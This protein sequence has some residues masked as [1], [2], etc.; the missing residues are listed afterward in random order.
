MK[1][2]TYLAACLCLLTATAC[3]RE[4]VVQNEPEV[5]VSGTYND[6]V[7]EKGWIRI[8]LREEA[9][10]LPV[11]AF[12]R[13]AI[14]TG[15]EQLDE[16][17][18]SLGVDE[19]R[20]VFADG[21]KFAERRRKYGMHL[22]YDL[23]F[24]EQTP[25]TRAA[26]GFSELNE[27]VS[28][29]E[30]VYKI[31]P[32]D[33][34][35][36]VPEGAIY[37]PTFGITRADA[38]MP[39]NDPMLPQQW[40]YHNE[41]GRTGFIAGADI[42][43]FEAWTVEKGKPNV[44]VSVH[45][46]GANLEH[47]DL[48]AH[49]WVNE[50]EASGNEKTDDD[51][52]GYNDDVN[53]W[54]YVNNSGK[55]DYSSHG[56]HTSGTISAINGNGEGVCGVAGGNGPEDGVRIMVL[57]IYPQDGVVVSSAP[58]SYAYAADNG[59]V[60]SQNSWTLGTTGDLPK[61]YETAFD[62]FIENAGT[63]ETGK[64]TGPMK[65]GIIIFAA[66]N[67]GGQTLLPAASDRVVGVAAMIP[68]YKMGSYSNHGPEIDLFA[69]GGSSVTTAA[70]QQVLSTYS[71]NGVATYKYLWGTSMACPHVSGVAGLIV[72][73]FGGDGFTVEECRERLLNAYRPVGGLVDDANLED[74]GHGLVDAAAA[75]MNDP[76]TK[77][78]QVTEPSMSVEGTKLTFSWTVPADGN[79]AA[80]AKY[81]V[82]IPYNGA[83]TENTFVNLY[84]VGDKVTYSVYA[85][86]D[87]SLPVT[88][89][90]EDRWGNQSDPISL[91]S[92]IAAPEISQQIAD[93]TIRANSSLDLNSYFTDESGELTFSATS[94][95]EAIVAAAVKNNIL[96]LTP[97]T[98]G[99][100]KVTVKATNKGGASAEQ[101][102]SVTV[103][104]GSKPTV[105]IGPNPV[106]DELSFQISESFNGTGKVTIYDMGA[107]KV[108]S[109]NTEIAQG[110]GKVAVAGL[111]AGN[112]I[113]DVQY[114]GNHVRSAFMKR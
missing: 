56:T 109:A 67:T 86:Y 85:R 96:T 44:I 66:G 12:T 37:L 2:A 92:G 14:A 101:T 65:G 26:E 58:D 89:V 4:D 87:P 28:C 49:F 27:L 31:R 102:F 91:D 107:R 78:A 23:H 43:L 97:K 46:D 36:E 19:I 33:S 42:N 60:I 75:L 35:I 10:T 45:D 57:Q 7:I 64:Q 103:S 114:E 53:G 69:P 113:L 22:W 32:T 94:S 72:S 76:E 39:F 90:V 1:R 81:L 110:A 105:T 50:A 16:L 41:G 21:G 108:M 24:D 8:K 63:D 59:A 11:G 83:E 15:N 99:T 47:P 9:Q 112:Y 84:D 55:I 93:M 73:H 68:N 82:K 98:A 74:V 29:I 111:S 79:G 6:D 77:P 51:N 62:Y 80:V 38:T 88:M 95:D 106:A 100:A 3:V 61:S 70:D 34:A 52:N 54:S 71:D 18:A 48:A 104:N 25:V 30:P 5:P 17:A 13:G 40:H 20:R